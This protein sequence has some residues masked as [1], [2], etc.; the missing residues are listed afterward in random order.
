MYLQYIT[1]WNTDNDQALLMAAF[2]EI[3]HVDPV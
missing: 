2:D 1:E 3:L